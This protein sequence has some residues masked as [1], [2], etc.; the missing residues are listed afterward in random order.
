MLIMVWYNKYNKCD[1]NN[2]LNAKYNFRLCC[3]VANC[4]CA[5]DV[6]FRCGFLFLLSVFLLFFCKYTRYMWVNFVHLGICV[7]YTAV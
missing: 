2:V 4:V 7:L 3:I 5:L 6:F 1:F